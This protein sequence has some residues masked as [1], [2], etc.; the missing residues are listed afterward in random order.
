MRKFFRLPLFM[1]VMLLVASSCLSD[2]EIITPEPP[3]EGDETADVLLRIRTPEGF[4]GNGT[5]TTLGFNDE[6]RLNTIT[7]LVFEYAT[8][9]F[10]GVRQGR[11]VTYTPGL[12]P[13]PPGTPEIS[14]TGTFEVTLFASTSATDFFRLVV[15]AN[16]ADEVAARLQFVTPG[17]SYNDVMARLWGTITGR[18]MQGVNPTI[19]MFGQTQNPVLI[20]ENTTLAETIRLHRAIAR[21]DVGVGTATGHTD[22][23]GFTWSGNNAQGQPIPFVLDRVYIMRPNNRFA[24]VPQNG[25]LPTAITGNPTI[26]TLTET[27]AFTEAQSITHFGFT[28]VNGNV[29]RQIYIPEANVRLP[30]GGV[31]VLDN[32][33][34]SGDANH[35]NRMAVIVGGFFDGSTTRTYYRVDLIRNQ[36][37]NRS[38]MNVLRNH[39][40]Q[41]NIMGVRGPGENCPGTA[42]RSIAMNMDVQVNEWEMV[43]EE[44]FF[45]GI[46]WIRLNHTRNE[47][48]SRHAILYRTANT[49]DELRFETTIPLHLWDMDGV[50]LGLSHGGTLVYCDCAPLPPPCGDPECNCPTVCCDLFFDVP[51]Q[52][53]FQ[54]VENDRFRVQ[55]IKTGTEIEP[56]TGRT[57]YHGFFRF[58]SLLPYAANAANNPSILHVEAGRIVGG[59]NTTRF[60]NFPITITQRG[61]SP[62]DWICGG[63]DDFELGEED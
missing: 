27:T 44:M 33:I 12:D 60:V 45:D 25:V 32:D 3:I 16:A 50:G 17:T 48:L 4:S 57:I 8:N 20:V 53:L 11:N 58:T 31:S 15:I 13:A 5:R 38:L 2:N 56:Q 35:I 61:D 51:G 30:H 29:H 36:A 46:E 37:D 49:I 42:Y 24:I 21:I 63:Y 39:L 41:I 19:P 10:I 1:A 6:N 43:T 9:A 47:S 22:E 59:G 62:D 26:P 52:T 40:Y 14:G 34:R 54:T 28:A 18:M 23:A 55:L 7:V